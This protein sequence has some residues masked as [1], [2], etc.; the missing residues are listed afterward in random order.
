MLRK[1]IRKIIRES[2]GVALNRLIQ[3]GSG[4]PIKP[5]KIGIE[6][7]PLP[8]NHMDHVFD[9]VGGKLD[10]GGAFFRHG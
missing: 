9:L 2:F 6:H 8:A 5:G 4:Y 10:F 3:C 1:L 7:N